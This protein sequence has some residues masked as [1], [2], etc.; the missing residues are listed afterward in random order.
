MPNEFVEQLII[1]SGVVSSGL[2]IADE[3]LVPGAQAAVVRVFGGL[4]E[5]TVSSGGTLQVSGG[6]LIRTLTV[7]GGAVTVSGGT[8]AGFEVVSGNLNVYSG[9]LVSGGSF[10]GVVAEHSLVVR[11]GGSAADVIFLKGNMQ[12]Q[13]GGAV[14]S[15]TVSGNNYFAINSGGSARELAVASG[16]Q[17]WIFGK[18][19]GARVAGG[20]RI[21]IGSGAVVS[22]G[23][24]SGTVMLS[25]G[26]M[27]D[28]VIDRGGR[29][30]LYSGGQAVGIDFRYW[31]YVYGGEIKDLT[32]TAAAADVRVL[33]GVADSVVVSQGNFV[34]S[35]GGTVFNAVYSQGAMLVSEGGFV[36]GATVVGNNN[37]SVFSGGRV[38]NMVIA[39]TGAASIL[40][41]A[42]GVVNRGGTLK[43]SSGG[44]A[45]NVTIAGGALELYSGAR[46]HQLA[47]TSGAR[48]NS[49]LGAMTDIVIENL[50][51]D[52]SGTLRGGVGNFVTGTFTLDI[53]EAT[54][55]KGTSF[56]VTDG[57]SDCG[58]TEYVLAVSRDGQVDG[59]YC[60]TNSGDDFYRGLVF[61]VRDE[62]GG[63]YGELTWQGLVN[64]PSM[65]YE[66]T[67]VDGW[68]PGI[69]ASLP[70]WLFNGDTRTAAVAT[71]D[72]ITVGTGLEVTSL[73]VYSGGSGSG[74]T[75]AAGGKANVSGGK[76]ADVAVQTGTVA[77]SSGG[78]VSGGIVD[79]TL[80]VYDGGLAD[81][82]NFISGNMQ[83]NS[84]G[85][86]SDI[87]VAGS[88]YFAVN[89]G[90]T[91]I[92]LNVVSGGVAYVFGTAENAALQAGGRINV[93]SGAVVSGGTVSG[94]LVVYEDALA[95]DLHFSSGN[96]QINSGGLAS[97]ITVAGS[98]YFAVNAG[99][100]AIG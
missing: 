4:D 82:I 3:V 57:F 60:F 36:S 28:I 91:A 68:C 90:G 87:T 98:N 8:V 49:G 30:N 72:R 23:T 9:G 55:A 12:V 78:V 58:A 7:S 41:S 95:C 21:E 99:A 45:L 69:V 19:D 25:G 51:I 32:L 50:T 31:G 89:A 39:S 18:V 77:V 61:T 46:V 38:E 29:L 26:L 22:G 73:T 14:T 93:S 24:V 40:G 42:D 67:N 92:G 84:G 70:V 71:A 86:A 66:F 10:D 63:E 13:S 79:G 16:G 37:F 43:I 20:G 96:M 52:Y 2:L 5:S 65:V 34:V 75:L 48:V 100:T 56:F 59:A 83:V 85:L 81:G 6:A 44:D 74:V 1:S 35:S 53:S 80:V 54:S 47:V 88:N 64:G 15:I 76:L 97:D 27:Q 33:G 17:A 94:T 62:L 11:S